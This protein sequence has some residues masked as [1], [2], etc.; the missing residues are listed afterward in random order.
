MFAAYCVVAAESVGRQLPI[1]FL[2]SVKEDFAKRYGD[3][4]AANASANSLSKEFGL[5]S[6]LALVFDCCS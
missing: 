2:E 3:G 4:K 6:S 5:F 1:A